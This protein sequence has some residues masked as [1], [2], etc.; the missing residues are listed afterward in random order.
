[1]TTLEII[2]LIIW[3]ICSFLIAFYLERKYSFFRTLLGYLSL[4][5]A[6]TLFTI[7]HNFAF[8]LFGFEEALFFVLSLLSLGASIFLFI[9]WIIKSVIRNV[10]KS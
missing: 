7:L 2:Y 9:I 5:G 1:M 3:I 6:F 10:S 8:G 4:L